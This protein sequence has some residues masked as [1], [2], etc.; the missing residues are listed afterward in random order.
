MEDGQFAHKFVA[1]EDDLELG[2]G[3]LVAWEP[4]AVGVADVLGVA[5]D[6]DDDET[7]GS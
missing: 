5:E 4:D 6:E 7:T 3:V 2:E 1:A